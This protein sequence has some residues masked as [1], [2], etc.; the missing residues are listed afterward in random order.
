MKLS[1]RSGS[2]LESLAH[3]PGLGSGTLDPGTGNQLEVMTFCSLNS[4]SNESSTS[5]RENAHTADPVMLLTGV[6]NTPYIMKCC[7]VPYTP[8]TKSVDDSAKIKYNFIN[9]F[10]FYIHRSEDGRCEK[11][12]R[13][14]ISI[15]SIPRLI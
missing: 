15:K 2:V 13:V 7:L 12:C 8:C 4:P 9:F 1:V 14:R 6:V 5:D 10:F 11:N 3:W